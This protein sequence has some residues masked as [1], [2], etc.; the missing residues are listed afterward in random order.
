MIFVEVWWTNLKTLSWWVNKQ[1]SNFRKNMAKIFCENVLN[2]LT[3]SP[4]IFFFHEQN[5]HVVIWKIR[6][7]FK[8]IFITTDFSRHGVRHLGLKIGQIELD[9]WSSETSIWFARYSHPP[10]SSL[11]RFYYIMAWKRMH[12][13]QTLLLFLFFYFSTPTTTKVMKVLNLLLKLW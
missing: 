2:R 9:L 1:Q 7:N 13:A 3:Q 11:G 10:D 12:P 5:Y 6:K 4:K 8:F